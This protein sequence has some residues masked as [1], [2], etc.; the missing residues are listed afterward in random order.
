[1]ERAFYCAPKSLG[2]GKITRDDDSY[3]YTAIDYN[4]KNF[5]YFNGYHVNRI[6]DLAKKNCITKIMFL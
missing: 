5:N 1:M 4:Y 3:G 6:C 2:K